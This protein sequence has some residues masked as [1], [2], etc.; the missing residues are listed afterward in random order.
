VAVI[1]FY[2]IDRPDLF[3]I[4]R[5]A[6]DRPGL[7]IKRL[8][9]LMPSG[10]IADI[11]AGDGFT[12]E[13]LSSPGRRV[14]AVEPAR[15]MIPTRR[16]VSRSVTWVQ[17]DAEELPFRDASL[18]GA[19]ATWAYF[20]SRGPDDPAAGI[21]ELH[22][23]VKPG[24]PLVIA[25]NAGG[26]EFT[27]MAS[28]DITADPR[29]WRRQGFGVEIVDTVFAFETTTDAWR[30]LDFYFDDVG[31]APPTELSYRVALFIGASR[32]V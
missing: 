25:D 1:P 11:G 19:Y 6:M 5:A 10:T 4:E 9:R 18:D 24:G 23:A 27:A 14:V 16:S 7:V 12:A 15:G 28:R 30:L 20:F 26:D 32:G 2:G 31:A 17:A 21:E 22:R 13:R 29:F 8:D 3:A